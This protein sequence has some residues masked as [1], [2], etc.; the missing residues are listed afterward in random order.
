MNKLLKHAAYKETT[1]ADGSKY[2]VK[3]ELIFKKPK[4]PI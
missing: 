4:Y 2:I 3:W 1:K